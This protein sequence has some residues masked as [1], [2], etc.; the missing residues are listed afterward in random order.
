MA[1]VLL[2][3]VLLTTLALS[4]AGPSAQA[5]GRPC[6]HVDTRRGSASDYGFSR[7][8]TFP[9]AT[10]PFGFNFWTPLTEPGESR[11]LY[12]YTSPS[13]YAFGISH[14]PSPWMG[15]YGAL[16]IWPETGK[17]VVDPAARRVTFRHADETARAHVYAVHLD[18]GIEVRLAPT[19]HAA[20]MSVTYPAAPKAY[21]LFDTLAAAQGQL[22]YDAEAR[23]IS[24]VVVH[25]PGPLYVWG[26]VEVQGASL[27]ASAARGHAGAAIALAAPSGATLTLR[28]GTSWLSVAQARANVEQELGRKTQREVEEEGARAWD[29]VLGQ[30]EIEGASEAQRII[31]YSNMYRAHMYPN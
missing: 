28:L 6:E 22:T 26:S 19:D 8:N 7:G 5:S 21:L 31:F 1:Q 9:A 10:R 12:K 25:G 17:L 15:D 20:I 3:G 23:A 16:Q 24:G 29:A 11:W 30:I 27:A 18:N 14:E 13:L 4:A 2:Q